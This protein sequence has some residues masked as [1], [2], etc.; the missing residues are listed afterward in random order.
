MAGGGDGPAQ[1]W[2]SVADRDWRALGCL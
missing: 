1:L 2:R